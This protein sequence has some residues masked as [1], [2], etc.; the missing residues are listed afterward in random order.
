MLTVVNSLCW[1]ISKAKFARVLAKPRNTKVYLSRIGLHLY[2][3]WFAWWTLCWRV[4]ALY[5]H[6]TT[7]DNHTLLYIKIPR[8]NRK[9]F[10]APQLPIIVRIAP[11]QISK[12]TI[13]IR[14]F[15]LASFWC[16]N[17]IIK[18]QEF[19]FQAKSITSA[20][21]YSNLPFQFV[22]RHDFCGRCSCFG[23]QYRQI[24]CILREDDIVLILWKISELCQ[25]KWNVFEH[26][27]SIKWYHGTCLYL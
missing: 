25:F 21:I 1:G 10:P 24:V 23:E 11:P 19:A 26:Y 14:P 8:W 22:P 20:S 12:I 18:L 3:V 15:L 16:I 6:Q 13:D 9:G 17:A 4:S 27:F 7:E 5:K 2:T